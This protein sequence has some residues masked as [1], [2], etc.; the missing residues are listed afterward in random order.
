MV[1]AGLIAAL[2]LASACTARKT[3][4]GPPPPA[5]AVSDPEVVQLHGAL[6]QRYVAAAQDGEVI[7][8]LRIDTRAVAQANRPPL[9]LALAIDTS[10]SME[11]DPI[12]H[13]RDAALSMVDKLRD[14]DRL[15]VVVFHSQTELLVESTVIDANTRPTIKAH[16]KTMKAAGTTDLAGGLQQAL[17]QTY[18]HLINDGVNRVVLLSDGVPND[19]SQILTLADQARGYSVSVTALGL[20]LD[21][22]ET[23]L[24]AVAQRS[25][26]SFHFIESSEAVAKVFDEEVLRLSRVVARQLMLTL[27]PGPG[28]TVNNAIGYPT[29]VSGRN[30]YVQLGDLSEGEERDVFVRLGVRGHRGGAN[31]E[32]MDAALSFQDAVVGAGALQRKLFLSVRSTADEAQLLEGR[33]EALEKDAVRAELAAV[34]VQAIA[35]ARSGQ[36]AQAQAILTD[37]A[38]RARAAAKQYDDTSFIEQADEIEKVN[39]DLPSVAPVPQP[40]PGAMLEDAPSLDEAPQPS[41]AAAGNV[42]RAHSN[43]VKTFQNRSPR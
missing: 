3:P 11:G 35:T 20:G 23:L 18:T 14:G 43:A 10:G 4:D 24:G 9:N 30:I 1:R 38:P 15:A 41:P 33:D 39:R 37:A 27:V 25:G 36:I 16:I 8:R 21:Y 12:D 19:E 31:V 5:V 2:A 22:N 29:G 7:A 28:V 40:Q 26:G 32:L 13:A 6:A 42:R 17:Q 34:V